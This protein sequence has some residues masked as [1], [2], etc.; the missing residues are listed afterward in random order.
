MWEDVDSIEAKLWTWTSQ[1]SAS[2]E[3]VYYIDIFVL[4]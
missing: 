3:A 2:V 4:Y 1:N